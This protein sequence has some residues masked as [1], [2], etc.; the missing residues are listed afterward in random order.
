MSASYRPANR[1]QLHNAIPCIWEKTA[2]GADPPPPWRIPFLQNNR[3]LHR[4]NQ[5][6][7]RCLRK[8]PLLHHRS[9]TAHFVRLCCHYFSMCCVVCWRARD[10]LQSCWGLNMWVEWVQENYFLFP[11]QEK[12]QN[13]ASSVKHSSS[14]CAASCSSERG[15]AL[16]LSCMSVWVTAD[17]RCNM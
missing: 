8:V 15:G 2:G 17:C 13:D 10:V 11:V 12:Q 7:A 3:S 1:L 6:L 14:V 16:P 5:T 4:N 9:V